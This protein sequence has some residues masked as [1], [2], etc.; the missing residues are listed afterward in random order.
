VIAGRE[1]ELSELIEGLQAGRSTAIVG[2]QGIGKTTLM[3][4]AVS[5]SGSLALEGG[6]LSTLRWMPW[7]PVARA[8]GRTPEGEERA[9]VADWILRT[10]PS[11]VLLLDDLQWADRETLGVLPLIC[12]EEPI[13]CAVRLGDP[14][15]SLARRIV[16]EAELNVID[17]APLTVEATVE[18]IVT[19]KPEFGHAA[20]VAVA[21][22]SG[23]NPLIALSLA[24]KGALPTSL[25]LVSRGQIRHLPDDDR[26]ALAL[27]GLLGRPAEPG[28]FRHSFDGL[29]AAGFASDRAGLVEPSHRVA[30]QA[31]VE[32][33][34]P[35]RR[36]ALHLEIATCVADPGEAA[37][38]YAQAGEAELAYAKAVE[39][40]ALERD[41]GRTAHLLATAAACAPPG[42]R[43]VLRIEAAAEL[44]RIGE[45]S[46]ARDLLDQAKPRERLRRGEVHLGLARASFWRGEPLRALREI[47]QG[48]KLIG[49][50]RHPI[51]TQ[52]HLE[53]AQLLAH[54]VLQDSDLSLAAA[55]DHLSHYAGP[56][57]AGVLWLRGQTRLAACDHRA[58]SDLQLAV[59]RARAQADTFLECVATLTQIDALVAFAH[60]T[61]AASM[62]QLMA[63]RAR[64]LCLN[65]FQAIFELL[66][67]ELQFRREGDRTQLTS[68][69]ERLATADGLG[70]YRSRAAGWLGRTLTYAGRDTEGHIRI[71]HEQKETPWPQQATWLRVVQ[72]ECEWLAG[73]P[74]IALRTLRSVAG[75]LPPQL[76]LNASVTEAWSLHDLGNHVPTSDLVSP[77]AA[78][79]GL[80][81]ERRAL[82]LLAG[83]GEPHEAEALFDQAAQ[84][85]E[86]SDVAAAVRCRWAAGEC[87]RCAGDHERA[88]G[89]LQDANRQASQFGLTPLRTR[90]RR[91]LTQY[92]IADEPDPSARATESIGLTPREREIMRFVGAGLSTRDIAH[93]LGIAPATVETQIRT[94]MRKLGA[95]TRVQ[96]AT[97]VWFRTEHPYPPPKG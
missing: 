13:L 37:M 17:L 62:C 48:L 34:T 89:R 54:G 68:G 55:I 70:P 22:E 87:A 26:D 31:A 33:L 38:H 93:A 18:L 96:A 41:V 61:E 90:I 84:V 51:S 39:A 14:G 2:V 46:A 32:L 95:S 19:A 44:L 29:V 78:L 27:L 88:A 5:G 11:G 91:S 50:P 30:S 56:N 60:E 16:D 6:G 97:A 24:L 36:A 9:D 3:R 86:S 53:L 72:A 92:G 83:S 10:K 28:T 57:D 7:L 58:L 35:D 94:A 47:D 85:V 63:A 49:Q 40:A 65:G 8:L 82:A 75:T 23:G 43:D 59:D 79:D 21:N 66:L 73:K 15:T 69:L 42:R 77:V 67:M 81:L 76:A 12:R 80:V 20:A 1:A 64:S 25:R 52:L 71:A 4:A 74:H 45:A